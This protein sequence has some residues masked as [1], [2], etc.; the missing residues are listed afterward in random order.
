M[1]KKGKTRRPAKDEARGKKS[2]KKDKRKGV[3]AA[4]GIDNHYITTDLDVWGCRAEPLGRA[5]DAV[6][7]LF[8]GEPY[9]LE[10]GGEKLTIMLETPQT[11]PEQDARL[12]L[13]AIQALSG[14]ALEAWREA[15]QRLLSP[16]IQAGNAGSSFELQL[17]AELLAELGQ[18]GLA[19]AVVVYPG[20]PGYLEWPLAAPAAPGGLR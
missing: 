7:G 13:D 18:A 4:R 8:A 19:L 2:R 12:L 20:S 3:A 15:D 10:A 9:P 16:G 14:E 5:F 17:P 11:S 1:G 6:D